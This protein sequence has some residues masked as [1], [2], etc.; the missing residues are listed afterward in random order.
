[1]RPALELADIF[2]EH[3]PGYR[4]SH[5][6]PLD[7][8]RVM[9]AI[10][11]CRTAALGGHIERLR[12]PIVSAYGRNK[13]LCPMQDTYCFG[14]RSEQ[15]ALPDAGYLLFRHTVGTSGFA[16]CSHCPYTYNA[17]NSCRNRH[18]PKCQSVARAEWVESRKLELLPVQYF[19]VVFTLPEPIAQVA[20]QN[21]AL[22][23]NI[24]FRASAETLLT[25]AGDRKHLGAGIGFFSVL[26]TWGQNLLH[27]PHRAKPPLRDTLKQTVI[28][29]YTASSPAAGFPPIMNAGSPAA[30]ASFSPCVCSHACSVVCFWNSFRKLSTKACFSSSAIWNRLRTSRRSPDIWR[31]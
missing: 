27:H 2:R 28:R 16:R 9:R 10:E 4:Q 20:L 26:H 12:I 1:M 23:Y 30:P 13:W 19:H 11:I 29:M 18:C 15:V 3:G 25:I 31:R 22:V 8:L 5:S 21:K 17:Y 6:L 7:Q 14:I 24:L